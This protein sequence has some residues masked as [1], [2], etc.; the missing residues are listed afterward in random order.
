MLLI[1]LL[2][3]LVGSLF[4]VLLI[5]AIQGFTKSLRVG[6]NRQG[7]AQTCRAGLYPDFPF[8]KATMRKELVRGQ[9]KQKKIF[10]WDHQEGGDE[11]KQTSQS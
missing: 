3:L 10:L 5:Q 8:W 2:R 7:G 1:I 11:Q 9:N 6:Q 4:G